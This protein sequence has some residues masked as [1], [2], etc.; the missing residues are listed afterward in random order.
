VHNEEKQVSKAVKEFSRFANQYDNYNIIQVEVAKTLVEQLSSNTCTTIIDIGCG[1]GEVYK[2]I[3]RNNIYF[4]QFI[5]LDSSQEMLNIHPAGKKIKKE[6]ADF[7]LS[8]TFDMF[9]VGHNG[10]VFSS[11][12]L[13]WSRDLDLTLSRLSK[14]ALK[15]HFAIF[16]S[17]TFKTLHQVAEVKSPIYSETDIKEMINKYYNAT[18]ETRKYTLHFDSVRDMF[19]Y[20]KKSGVSGGEKKL[21]YKQMKHLMQ[22]YPLDYLEFEVLFVNADSI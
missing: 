6:C 12:A 2:N 14:K 19:S 10:I 17:S 22:A 8:K 21:S 16:T 7:N 13:Q 1:S 15:A 5:A 3:E 11:S 20:I 18:F 4:E 9:T